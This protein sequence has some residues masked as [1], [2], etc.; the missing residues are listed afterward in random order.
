L[1]LNRNVGRGK[2]MISFI[3]FFASNKVYGNKLAQLRK[4]ESGANSAV[5][6]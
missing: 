3:L 1:P 6:G 4:I 5:E 2:I